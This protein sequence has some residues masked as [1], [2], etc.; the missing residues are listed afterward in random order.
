M[1]R[2][3][4]DTEGLNAPDVKALREMPTPAGLPFS[5]TKIGFQSGLSNYRM[6]GFYH[7]HVF[8]KIQNNTILSLAIL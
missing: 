2:G 7:L 5:I 6:K 8:F 3:I 4:V 1:P